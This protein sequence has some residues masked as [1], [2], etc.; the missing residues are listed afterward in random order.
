MTRTGPN[1]ARCIVWALGEYKSFFFEFFLLL[2]N[3]LQHLYVLNYEITLQRVRWKVEARK[4]GQNDAR[5]VVLA[6]GE[7]IF[8]F[9]HVFLLLTNFLQYM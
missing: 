7:C 6:L 5:H 2:T 3:L 4:M 9:F 1:D 8:Y